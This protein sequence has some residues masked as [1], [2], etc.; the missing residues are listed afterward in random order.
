METNWQKMG[1]DADGNPTG[2]RSAVQ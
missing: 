1:L 2:R